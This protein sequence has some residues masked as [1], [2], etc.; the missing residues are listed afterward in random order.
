MAKPEQD[1][2]PIQR[3]TV[4]RRT[5]LVLSILKGEATVREAARKH[6]LKGE[7]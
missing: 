1:D 5:A 7:S 4:R 3:W 2:E 6:G